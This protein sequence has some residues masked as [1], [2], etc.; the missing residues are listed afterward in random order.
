[1]N[2][3]WHSVSRTPGA[4]GQGENQAGLGAKGKMDLA[5]SPH[6]WDP[7]NTFYW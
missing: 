7:W 3:G 5:R 2:S 1:M 6:Q 4:E